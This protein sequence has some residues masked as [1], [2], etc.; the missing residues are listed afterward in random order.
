MGECEQEGSRSSM[1]TAPRA[2][3]GSASGPRSQAR[4]PRK[5]AVRHSGRRL[6]P[7]RDRPHDGPHLLG[8]VKRMRRL[9]DGAK[10]LRGI[11]SF[12]AHQ[13]R[14]APHSPHRQLDG[15]GA[16]QRWRDD[17]IALTTNTRR[18]RE[19]PIVGLGPRGGYKWGYKWGVNLFRGIA[20][21]IHQTAD[22]LG[23]AHCGDR[24]LSRDS[25]FDPPGQMSSESPQN[26]N[27]K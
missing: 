16:H 9:Q 1:D 11:G 17:E 22:S 3:I 13:L 23:G 21:V 10:A 20:R 26:P 25:T 4:C 18:R 6:V 15:A 14:K 27:G 8:V 24:H 12:A 5:F 7:T 2:P 19:R